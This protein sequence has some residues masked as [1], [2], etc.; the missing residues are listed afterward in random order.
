M[1]DGLGAGVVASREQLA[2]QLHRRSLDLGADMSRARVIVID[3]TG[4]PAVDSAVANHLIQTV[5]AARLMGAKAFVC[6]LSSENA[7]TLVRLGIELGNVKTVGS[8]SD[9]VELA[10]RLLDEKSQ[11]ALA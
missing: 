1:S 2:A 10:T 8:L 4:V 11:P 5:R 3:V 6:G 7:Q 9:A